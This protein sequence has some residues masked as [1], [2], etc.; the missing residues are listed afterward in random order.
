MHPD[1]LILS[2]NFKKFKRSSGYQRLL[3]SYGIPNWF[4]EESDIQFN[5][6]YGSIKCVVNLVQ[7]TISIFDNEILI[8][9][10]TIHG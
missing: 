1:C 2:K 8:R 4:E 3:T 5:L 10:D 7:G 9:K 6:F